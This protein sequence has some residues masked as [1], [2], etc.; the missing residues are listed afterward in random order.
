MRRDIVC[1]VALLALP[2]SAF[3]QK[4][5]LRP[6]PSAPPTTRADSRANGTRPR[7]S[8]QVFLGERAPDFELDGSEG[9]PVR[10]S[11]MRGEW[12]ALVFSDRKERLSGFAD[13]AGQLRPLGVRL[14]AVC[15][16][17][18]RALETFVDKQGL[19]FLALADPTGE[20]SSVYGV[21]DDEHSA[22]RPG[23]VILDRH[24]DAR[25]IAIGQELPAEDV[26]RLVQFATQGF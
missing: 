5:E 8:G 7:V 9:R 16:E 26:V 20:I 21:Y 17:K 3:A 14:V 12:V 1:L 25:F 15:H 18:A 24:G 23:L 2:V 4:E 6:P 11:S 19:S 22:T 13:A 10:L